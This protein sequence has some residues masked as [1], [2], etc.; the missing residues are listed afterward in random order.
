VVLVGAKLLTRKLY[1][2]VNVNLVSWRESNGCH[3]HIV[4]NCYSSRLCWSFANVTIAW[5]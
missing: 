3:R 2:T 5:R 4:S 1:R